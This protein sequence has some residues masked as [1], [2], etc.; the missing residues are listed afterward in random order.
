MEHPN[1]AQHDAADR[2]ALNAHHNEAYAHQQR[3]GDHDAD[4][5]FSGHS[6][7]CDV[8]LQI[9]LVEPCAP[10]PAVELF[11]A[12]CKAESRE[13]QKRERGQHGNHRTHGA[14]T[15]TD[16]A[17]YDVQDLLAVPPFLVFCALFEIVVLPKC[18]SCPCFFSGVFSLAP[19]GGLGGVSHSDDHSVLR[20]LKRTCLSWCRHY[21]KHLR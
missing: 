3:N 19:F 18:R 1:A 13:H 20:Q 21:T 15:D 8:I 14:K 2:N 9:V 7:A 5:G 4:L 16:A 10:E 17:E 6:P 11:R 12:S